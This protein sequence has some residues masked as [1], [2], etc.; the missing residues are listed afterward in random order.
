[1]T[2]RLALC[3]YTDTVELPACHA[4]IENYKI[5]ITLMNELKIDFDERKLHVI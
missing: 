2:L 1:M 5:V 4:V 3:S